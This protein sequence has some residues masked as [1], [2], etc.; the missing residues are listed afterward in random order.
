MP[1]Y[2]YVYKSKPEKK[3][4]YKIFLSGLLIIIFISSLYFLSSNFYLL[5]STK[6]ISPVSIY[7]YSSKNIS[8]NSPIPNNSPIPTNF[9]QFQL[10]SPTTQLPQ[11]PL[12]PTISPTSTFQPQNLSSIL[13]PQPSKSS[14]SIAIIGDSMV[15]TMGERLEYL[16]HALK[17]KYPNTNF[18]L[19]NYGK[20]AENVQMGLNRFGS[21]LHYQD[22]NYP[23]LTSLKPD[24]LI[25]G[26]FAYNPFSPYD[27]DRHWLTLTKLVQSAQLVSSQIYLLA[28]ISPLRSDFGKGPNGVN[29]DENT[30]YVHSGHIIEQEENA[31]GLAKN[32]NVGLID[33]FT[34][35]HGNRSLVNPSD[36]IHPSVQG[37]EFTAEIIV[38]QIKLN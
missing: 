29:W 35:S 12:T 25:V 20:G 34:P 22:R 27:R 38:N 9:N 10:P 5:S 36:G 33:A 17:K 26:S 32:L 3:S 23:L 15:D 4:D 14:Y 6:I 19:Y 8:T 13:Y 1:L 28:E 24:I 16:E 18:T 30:A 31:I 2:S 37:H 11:I 21:E 7:A